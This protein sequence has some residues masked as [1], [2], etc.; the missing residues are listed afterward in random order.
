MAEAEEVA[1][2]PAEEAEAEA[3]WVPAAEAV[4][5]SAPGEEVAGASAPVEEAEAAWVP[6]EAAEETAGMPSPRA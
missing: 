3:A 6:A 1:G 5:G 2:A 4:A